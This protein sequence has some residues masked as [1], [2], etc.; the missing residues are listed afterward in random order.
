MK[1]SAALCQFVKLFM[2]TMECLFSLCLIPSY[3]H[4][5]GWELSRNL[6][7]SQMKCLEFSQHP[8]SCSNGGEQNPL[9]PCVNRYP[10]ER[11]CGNQF[12]Y[13]VIHWIVICP[14]DSVI[15]LLN[16]WGVFICEAVQTFSLNVYCLD[17]QLYP[18]INSKGF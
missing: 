16:N 9:G 13:C 3:K 1:S 15:H 8:P 10:V 7:K 14:V 6:C 17:N 5:T 12:Y 4:S 2:K 11:F 18:M